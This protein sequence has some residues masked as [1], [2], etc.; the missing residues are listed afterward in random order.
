VVKIDFTPW[1][2]LTGRMTGVNARME[3]L[4]AAS[5]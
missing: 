2:V 4:H 3:S 1:N 5:K